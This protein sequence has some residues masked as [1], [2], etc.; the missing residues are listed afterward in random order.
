M[1]SRPHSP[2]GTLLAAATGFALVLL[3]VS[4]VN[5]ALE[6]LRQEFS[7][8]ITGLQ[9]V[10][11]A[12]TLAFAALLLTSGALGDRIGARRMF[13]WGL[14]LFTLSSLLCGLANSLELLIAARLAQGIGAAL[15]VP[16]SLSMLQ[17]AFQ[18]A[19]ARNRA[20]GWWGAV[21][22]LALAAG[23]VLGGVLVTH[24]GWRAIFL[25]NLPLGMIGLV[26]T[27]R[28]VPHDTAG[29]RRDLDWPGQ[30]AAAV[31]LAALTASLI[32]AGS[33]GWGNA[34]VLAGLAA[35][36]LGLGAFLWIESHAPT[37]MLPLALFR[38]PMFTVSS[39]S[40]MMVNFAYYGLVFVLSLF[41][42]IQQHLSP[43][44][45]G[46]AFLPM[47]VVLIGANIVAGRLIARL[48][49]RR[50]MVLGLG[51]ATAGYLMLLLASR[52]GRYALLVV[53]MLMAGGGIALTIPTMTNAT[54]S[55][56]DV[57]RAGIASGV[58]NSARQ[59]G[60]MLGVAVFGYMVRDTAPRAFMHGMYA[61]MALA[62]ASLAL[63]ALLCLAGMPGAPR[64]ERP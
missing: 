57:S 4:V 19:I 60:G 35:F 51:L 49:A 43:Q 3:D 61:S 10:V 32:E 46:F 62:V 26:L 11:N 38:V 17:R 20:V 12:Y 36:A 27:L 37:P 25:L 29:A 56:V 2:R 64:R 54:L 42:Q 41:F 13:L 23:P 21:G 15:L 22:A 63:G 44:Q 39:V 9:W 24:L 47:T 55:S 18:S 8:G 16:N 28:H 5:V 6:A 48:G 7:T 34:W 30:A 33:R 31:A 50:L 1:P 40:G 45:A 52:D 58:L 59:I 14:T 53:P